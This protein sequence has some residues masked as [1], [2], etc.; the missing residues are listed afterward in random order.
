MTVGARRPGRR[1]AY[2]DHARAGEVD[3]ET[4][5]GSVAILGDAFDFA[6][7]AKLKNLRPYEQGL[8]QAT[9]RRGAELGF[10]RRDV[11]CG[12]RGLRSSRVP[13]YRASAASVSKHSLLV[14]RAI[15]RAVPRRK[16]PQFFDGGGAVTIL[17]STE[18]FP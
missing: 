13:S 4:L 7:K 14:V 5:I 10:L 9:R 16:R 11:L 6:L 1:P 2:R 17:E 15:H 8:E 18:N 3:V 12:R